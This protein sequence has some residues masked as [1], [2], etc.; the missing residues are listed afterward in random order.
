M[1]AAN[2]WDTR[3]GPLAALP[4]VKLESSIFESLETLFK[5]RLGPPALSE[6]AAQ[7]A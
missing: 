2:D 7:S 6:K 3:C 5:A 1:F 4:H